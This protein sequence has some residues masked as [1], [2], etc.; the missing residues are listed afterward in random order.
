MLSSRRICILYFEVKRETGALVG[1]EEAKLR[2]YLTELDLQAGD[3]RL[4]AITPDMAEPPIIGAIADPRLTWI[5]FADLHAAVDALITP[6]EDA[7]AE[8]SLLAEGISDRDR[9]LL[10]ELQALFVDDKLFGGPDVVI[11]A[12]NNAYPEY[13]HTH[14]YVCQPASQRTF[15]PQIKRLGF[16]ASGAIQPEVPEIL[17][18][19]GEVEISARNVAALHASGIESDRLFAEAI[20]RYMAYS[21]Y[22]KNAPFPA[23][24]FLLAAPTDPGT[25]LFD[26][27]IKNTTKARTGRGY[28][29]T[30]GQ[31]YARADALR[32]GP[33]TTDELAALGG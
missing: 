4:I 29:W 22:A 20:E 3:A 25:R 13:Q 15:Q 24:I 1:S 9:F 18:H 31:R 11:V 17:D 32:R 26:R 8:L 7:D 6:P 33:S 23:Q 19:R 27:P 14:A 30:L 16:Y 21:T 5:S 12:A 2:D 10:R 28:A